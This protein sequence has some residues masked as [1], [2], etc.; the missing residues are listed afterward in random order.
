MDTDFWKI[1]IESGPFGISIALLY[2]N[3]RVIQS[4]FAA[5]QHTNKMIA[6]ALNKQSE[7]Q[8]D[9]KIEIK[10]LLGEIR[11]IPCLLNKKKDI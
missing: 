2:V 6:E 7:A 9:L 4:L 1:V 10:Q 11:H 5:L 8:T 3:S